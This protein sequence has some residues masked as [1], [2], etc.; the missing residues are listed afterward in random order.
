MTDEGSLQKK[1]PLAL[2]QKDEEKESQEKNTF[3]YKFLEEINSP[4]IRQ[5]SIPKTW[6]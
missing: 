4:D 3:L 1:L 6:P 2:K 5:H